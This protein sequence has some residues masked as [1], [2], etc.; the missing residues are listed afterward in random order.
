MYLSLYFVFNVITLFQDPFLCPV[1]ANSEA[2]SHSGLM[3]NSVMQ[4]NNSI[5]WALKFVIIKCSV[6]AR[7]PIKADL[8]GRELDFSIPSSLDLDVHLPCC[9]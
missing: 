4:P 8:F 5:G 1:L 9:W 3:L 6:L 7:F 2:L